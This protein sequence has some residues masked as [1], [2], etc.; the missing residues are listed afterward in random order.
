MIVEALLWTGIA[1]F[2]PA[3][4]GFFWGRLA[5]C[6][7][8]G[9]LPGA[10]MA[11]WIHSLGIPYVALITGAVSVRD[12]GLSGIAGI[13]W[14]RGAIVCAGALGVAWVATGWRRVELP[15][16]RPGRAAEDEPRWALYRGTASLL[17]DPRWAGPLIGLGIGLLDWFLRIRPWAQRAWPMPA[18]WSDLVRVCGST[19]LFLFT[20]NLWLIVLTQAG[21]SLVFTRTVQSS[22]ED[23]V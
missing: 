14:L 12:V 16:A 3:I 20:R 19:A 11:R 22:S 1:L 8:D 18:E 17:A 6:L 4:V 23:A 9:S 21:L 13:E 15:Y 7:G 5:S 10:S 2:G